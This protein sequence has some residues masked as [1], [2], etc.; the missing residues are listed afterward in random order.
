VTAGVRI[1]HGTLAENRVRMDG[2]GKDPVVFHGLKWA[3]LIRAVHPSFAHTVS[4][5][6][7]RQFSAFPDAVRKQG[8]QP[9]GGPVFRELRRST[10]HRKKGVPEP[11]AMG[12]KDD[13]RL[14]LPVPDK[15]VRPIAPGEEKHREQLRADLCK[16]G[17]EEFLYLPWDLHSNTMLQELGGKAVPAEFRNNDIRGQWKDWTSKHWRVTYKFPSS[18]FGYDTTKQDSGW[19]KERFSQPISEKNG[20]RVQDCIDDRERRLLR[21]LVPILSPDKP[22][23]CT[24]KLM[25]AIYEA[26]FNYRKI[27]WGLIVEEFVIREARKLGNKKGCPLTPFLFHLYD[28]YGCLTARERE[29]WDNCRRIMNRES[30]RVPEEDPDE[31]EDEDSSDEEEQDE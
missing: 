10:R 15:L 6:P 16:M 2:S 25:K 20:F 30:T 4:S 21:F 18:P 23:S 13:W 3:A 5:P 14:G 27:G 7:L 24:I 8:K 1:G 19:M 9:G 11:A 12:K 29:Q 28:K 26:Y 17:C 22:H 31:S